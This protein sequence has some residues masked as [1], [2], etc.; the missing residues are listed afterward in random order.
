MSDDPL[1]DAYR[2]VPCSCICG[3]NIAWVGIRPSGAE[4]MIGCVCHQTPLAVV[5][6]TLRGDDAE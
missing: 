5:G 2:I 1:F 6:R 3:G 4:E